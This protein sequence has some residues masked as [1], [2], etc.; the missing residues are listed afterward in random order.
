MKNEALK[1]AIAE[2]G[3][4]ALRGFILNDPEPNLARSLLNA[5]A[6]AREFDDKNIEA[7]LYRV[8]AEL[9]LIRVPAKEL[10]ARF[11]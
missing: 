4:D 5:E 10:I 8:R 3:G 1:R 2:Y 11:S 6:F 7:G 9:D